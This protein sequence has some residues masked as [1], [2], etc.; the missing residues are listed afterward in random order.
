MNDADADDSA[1]VQSHVQNAHPRLN[2]VIERFLSKHNN[3]VSYEATYHTNHGSFGAV[4]KVFNTGTTRSPKIAKQECA[5]EIAIL[6]I[7]KCEWTVSLRLIHAAV[8]VAIP[9]AGTEFP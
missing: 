6:N 4:L 3:T 2:I 7:F 9:T 5:N 8:A 1:D